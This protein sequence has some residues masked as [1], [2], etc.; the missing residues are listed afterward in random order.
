LYRYRYAR[1]AIAI[2]HTEN[3][4]NYNWFSSNPRGFAEWFESINQPVFFKIAEGQK[5]NLFKKAQAIY[6]SF[7]E[8]PDGL[9]EMPMLLS[10][11]NEKSPLSSVNS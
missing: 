8:V 2:T 1:D 10:G 11:Q 3:F 7:D 6:A 5:R 4:K 9:V